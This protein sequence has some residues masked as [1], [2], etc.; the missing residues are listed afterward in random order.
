MAA[1]PPPIEFPSNPGVSTDWAKL[2]HDRRVDVSDLAV[3]LYAMRSA[4]YVRRM[5]A[6]QA[7]RALAYLHF[8]PAHASLWQCIGCRGS[9]VPL[10]PDGRL[11]D[12]GCLICSSCLGGSTMLAKCPTHGMLFGAAAGGEVRP[13]VAIRTAEVAA[14]KMVLR[15]VRDQGKLKA[16]IKEIRDRIA[17]VDDEALGPLQK[18][19]KAGGNTADALKEAATQ[20]CT[21]QREYLL[22]R[23]RMIVADQI[24]IGETGFPEFP[25][26]PYDTRKHQSEV[27]P[28][29]ATGHSPAKRARVDAGGSF[30]QP[31]DLAPDMPLPPDTQFPKGK[32]LHGQ[33]LF[34]SKFAGKCKCGRP[35]LAGRTLM[36]F[37]GEGPSKK[38]ICTMCGIEPTNTYTS[39][40]VL[41]IVVGDT[42]D[43]NP[44]GSRLTAAERD[45]V[46]AATAACVAD[47]LDASEAFDLE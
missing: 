33:S 36:T 41:S 19:I 16:V 46:A 32:R 7:R 43:P 10:L 12:C 1:S 14:A 40:M 37:V 20:A 47:E 11:L 8:D 4:E 38:C 30:R 34:P 42:Q 31:P 15:A 27:K 2:A 9:T 45:D 39:D 3:W 21:A 13:D 24:K 18:R 17:D 35:K 28:R 44:N 26:T 23:C 5:A 25:E 6:E 29:S 22:E